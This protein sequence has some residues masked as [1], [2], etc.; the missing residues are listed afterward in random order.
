MDVVAMNCKAKKELPTSVI[1]DQCERFLELAD[2]LV[3]E[4]ECKLLSYDASSAD[5]KKYHQAV[6][7]NNLETDINGA[8]TSFVG[9]GVISEDP[10]FW[11]PWCGFRVVRPMTQIPTGGVGSKMRNRFCFS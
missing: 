2:K 8:K 4:K 6:L 1:E 3:S 9:E 5:A 11:E 7:G 10:A